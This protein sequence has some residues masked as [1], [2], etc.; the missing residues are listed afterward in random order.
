MQEPALNT[1]LVCLGCCNHAAQ[2]SILGSTRWVAS[3]V[4]RQNLFR[5]P[6]PAARGLLTSLCCSLAYTSITLT[7]PFLLMWPSAWLCVCTKPPLFIGA[8]LYG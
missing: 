6:L 5:A 4:V 7:S 8:E 3:E 1:L 2:T